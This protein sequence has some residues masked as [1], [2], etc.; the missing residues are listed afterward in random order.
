MGLGTVELVM[1]TE[2]TFGVSIPDRDAERIRTAGQ[3]TDWLMGA[4]A[5]RLAVSR[6]TCAS[7]NVFHE[8]RRNLLSVFGVARS[9]VRVDTPIH[10]LVTERWAQRAWPGF[11]RENNIDVPPFS[12]R[13]VTRF[14]PQGTTIRDL[15]G[16]AVKRHP[17]YFASEGRID[18]EKVFGVIRRIVVEQ[19]HVAADTITED[20]DLVRLLD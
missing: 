20:T 19:A 14:A 7:R 15:V 13:T 18:R 1:E 3:L 5:K 10:E 17:L 12:F 4:L 16:Q 6:S 2:D 8:L 11:A 9:R